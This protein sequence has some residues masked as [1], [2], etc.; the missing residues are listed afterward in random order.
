MS[1]QSNVVI[2]FDDCDAE[3]LIPIQI[4][5]ENGE[6]SPILVCAEIEG[7]KYAFEPDRYEAVDGAP[8]YQSLTTQLKLLMAFSV[9]VRP[10]FVMKYQVFEV[11][12][13]NAYHLIWMRLS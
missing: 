9:P 4:A 11:T 6:A 5:R 8:W 3:W 12:D 1:E 7:V 2:E 10:D 13:I